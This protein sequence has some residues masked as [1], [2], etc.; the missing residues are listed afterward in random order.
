MF[1]LIEELTSIYLVSNS[2]SQLKLWLKTSQKEITDI[3]VL[4]YSLQKVQ[5]T[6]VHRSIYQHKV[7]ILG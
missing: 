3:R 1:F 7:N 6:M 2:Y 4:M 5:F